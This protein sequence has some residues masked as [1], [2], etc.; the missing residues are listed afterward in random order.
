MNLARLRAECLDE[1]V[2]VIGKIVMGL[3]DQYSKLY[4]LIY[5]FAHVEAQVC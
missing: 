4:L 3:R 5:P 2:R 1:I